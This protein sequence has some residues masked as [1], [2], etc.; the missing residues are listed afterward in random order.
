MGHIVELS[1]GKYQLIADLGTR[2]GERLRRKKTVEAKNK[3]EAKKMLDIFEAELKKSEGILFGKYR[4]TTVN[5]LYDL[6]KTKYATIALA[7]RTADEYEKIIEN[8][9]LPVFGT[10]KV[11]D[12]HEVDVV[13][14]FTDLQ[15]DGKRLD[16]KEGK[17]SSSTIHNIFKAFTSLLSAAKEWK[18][19]ESNPLNA[20]KLPT[21][22][23]KKGTAYSE[24]E[25]AD[26]MAL[27]ERDATADNQLIVLIALTTGCRAGEVA[28]LEA[29]H[30]NKESNTITV[31]Q[32]MSQK[33][34][35]LFLKSTK[36]KRVR[37]VAVPEELMKRLQKQKLRKMSHLLTLG[38]DR[39]WPENQFLFSDEF[40]KPLRP[41][42]IGQFWS[43]FM[44]RNKIRRIRFH[45]LR[46]TSATHLINRGVHAKVIQERLGHSTIGTTMNV[47]GH[48]L[49]KA[50]QTAAKHFEDLFSEK[51]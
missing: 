44:G 46:H 40:G 28:A 16:G 11:K 23:H 21:L 41:D 38:K 33:D 42:S 34:G 6:W 22:E 24:E 4:N 30:L 26:L 51:K 37:E 31:A 17:L 14:F 2:A 19:I 18:I 25:L 49:E 35:K 27:L 5:A 12:I 8:R 1:K 39:Q 7:P 47:Y 13:H 3:T 45:D 50:D 15:E 9:V 32:S 43:R 10:F 36:T 29:K 20:V 48:V